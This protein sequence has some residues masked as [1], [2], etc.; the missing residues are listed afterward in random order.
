M[1]GKGGRRWKSSGIILKKVQGSGCLGCKV[2]SIGMGHE[3]LPSLLG[4]L[5]YTG[6]KHEHCSYQFYPLEGGWVDRPNALRLETKC[7][8]CK[9]MH[10]DCFGR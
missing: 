2:S 1:G 9:R 10:T 6:T 8:S 5:C 3:R 7:G 4:M